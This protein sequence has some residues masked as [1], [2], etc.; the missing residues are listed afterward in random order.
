MLGVSNLHLLT[1]EAVSHAVTAGECDPATLVWKDVPMVPA[2]FYEHREKNQWGGV[3]LVK[4][5]PA[6]SQPA[7]SQ[8]AL[9]LRV[10]GAIVDSST[11][12]CSEGVSANML[13]RVDTATVG[14]V[15]GVEERCVAYLRDHPDYLGYTNYRD[16][17]WA[18]TVICGSQLNVKV[19]K[20]D[21]F[22]A[23]DASTGHLIRD[24]VALRDMHASDVILRF[25]GLWRSYGTAA[26]SWFL[27]GGSFKYE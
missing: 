3:T 7:H 21:S 13:F 2:Y 4:S 15:N 5:Q 24:P 11:S 17:D 9:L 16:D 18:P 23:V 10:P 27:L 22:A 1:S 19:I 14:F 8:P 25:G 26:A 20:G 6:H 12:M